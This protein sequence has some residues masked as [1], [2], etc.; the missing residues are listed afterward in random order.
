MNF[1]I[2]LDRQM[3]FAVNGLHSAFWDSFF[4]FVTSPAT[5]IPLY[6]LVL[7]LIIYKFKPDVRCMAVAVIA[8]L[9]TFFLTDFLSVHLF[10]DVFKRLRP[11][12]DPFTRDAVRAITGR[13]GM[14]GFVSNHASNM[15]GFS[16]VSFLIL[17]RKWFG[18]L[19]F[20]W[21]SIVA[22]SRVYLGK[23]FPLDVICGAAFGL[24]VAFLVYRLYICFLNTNMFRRKTTER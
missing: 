11:T 13:G 10:K 4:V 14:Y 3:M 7:A 15:F 23:H 18:W 6:V 19:L 1:I 2:N 22:Y 20:I 5:S 21:S 12:W 16:L 8:I 24:L 17:R 9:F